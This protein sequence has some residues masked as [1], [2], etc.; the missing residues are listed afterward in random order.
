MRV[1]VSIIALISFCC[2]TRVRAVKQKMESTSASQ[3]QAED[4]LSDLDSLM[5]LGVSDVLQDLNEKEPEVFSDL[6]SAAMG[7]ETDSLPT[8]LMAEIHEAESPAPKISAL[9]PKIPPKHRG[10]FVAK[11]NDFMRDYD[12]EQKQYDKEI[13]GCLKELEEGKDALESLAKATQAHEAGSQKLESVKNNWG[14]RKKGMV[15]KWSAADIL[16]DYNKQ[17]KTEQQL[18]VTLKQLRDVRNSLQR[19]WKLK[20]PNQ[21][22][23]RLLTK[24]LTSLRN[25]CSLLR[26]VVEFETLEDEND[27]E[28]KKQD[29][30]LMDRIRLFDRIERNQRKLIRTKQT[31]GF[32]A[33]HPHMKHAA[34]HLK[35]QIKK[36]RI[37]SMRVQRLKKH[38]ASMPSNGALIKH[39][40]LRE[41]RVHKMTSIHINEKK[42][43]QK[44]KTIKALMPKVKEL[45]QQKA[46]GLTT[47][48]QSS[49]SAATSHVE[50]YHSPAH[51]EHLNT[52][53]KHQAIVHHHETVH[54]RHAHV[55]HSSHAEAH[56]SHHAPVHKAEHGHHLVSHSHQNKPRKSVHHFVPHTAAH[57]EHVHHGE[58][59]H[60]SHRIVHKKEEHP[61]SHHETVSVHHEQRTHHTE[62]TRAHEIEQIHKAQ[63]A[64]MHQISHVVSKRKHLGHA[65][66]QQGH[67]VHHTAV[68]HSHHHE[69]QSAHHQPGEHIHQA[70]V[71]SARNQRHSHHHHESQAHHATVVSHGHHSTQSAS[72][73]AAH[74]HGADHHQPIHHH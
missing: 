16:R 38:L 66:V 22:T 39:E 64:Q 56:V 72:S 33:K 69:G 35:N 30:Q 42:H 23:L 14:A 58:G 26:K 44:M 54:H 47:S 37:R 59:D 19:Q 3:S 1:S 8:D 36:L 52:H 32:L 5:S 6:V 74:S 60:A 43:S 49:H 4:L 51:H 73:G 29:L 55:H 53:K 71:L 17:D 28:Y 41:R 31:I 63:S 40:I 20:K 9:L 24:Q 7:S 34:K 70:H 45:I 50:V 46:K 18:A 61:H 57:H 48:H 21:A 65:H 62:T 13:A 10:K 15:S 68:A 67:A 12:N 27:L 2:L 25:K 11:R